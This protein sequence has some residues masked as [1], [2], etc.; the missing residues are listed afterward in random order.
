[1]PWAVPQRWR[2]TAEIETKQLELKHFS[3]A[4]TNTAVV[5]S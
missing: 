4:E 5:L 3:T 1:M 2:R